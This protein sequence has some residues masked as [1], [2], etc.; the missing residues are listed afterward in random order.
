[1][2]S[3]DEVAD[4]AVAAAPAR[5]RGSGLLGPVAVAA[6]L[7]SAL[8]TFLIFNSF[9]PI[10][11][12]N[13]VV[14][15]ILLVNAITV[16]VLLGLIAREVFNVFQARRHGQAGARL[17]VRT[18]GLFSV[19]AAVP[20][21]LLAV[22]ASITL[23]RGLDRWFSSRTR[24]VIEN[25]LSVAQAYVR[26]HAETVR[27]DI[28]AMAVDL[29]R[30]KPM[31]DSDRERF[32]QFLRAQ[33]SIRGLPA[34]LM[35]GGDLQT[36]ERA[37]LG[38]NRDFRGPSREALA[39]V[40]ESEPQI[41]LLPNADYVAAIIKLRS[42]DDTYL[43]VAR[44][45]NPQVL[46]QLRVTEAGVLEYANLD[47]RRLGV[48][49]A[50][51]LMFTVIALICL[52]SAAWIGINFAASLVAPIRRL[53]GAASQVSTGNLYVQVPV[54]ESE[55]DLAH[56][57]ETF[58]KMTQELRTQHDDLMRAHDVIDSR[59]RFTEAVLAGASAGV[60]GVDA[61]GC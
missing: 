29:A 35:I 26:E 55:G 38:F 14:V 45:L 54:R 30:A 11:P 32:R 61:D 60:I 22:V 57:G 40:G 44:P 13:E 23:D 21:I 4:A 49:V 58:N 43:Y 51:G 7:L 3:V 8:A 2:T 50:F 27:G 42:Y 41:A 28:M 36:I 20:A 15:P 59:R 6:A 1:M 19:M 25:S 16:L 53:I 31:F 56:L 34:A 5:R 52:L 10:V 48:Q 46:E 12:T 18:V 24:A 39:E 33:A 17:H 37:D 47:A 9:T